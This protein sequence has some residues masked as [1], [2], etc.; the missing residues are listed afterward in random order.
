M[1]LARNLFL[2]NH[3]GTGFLSGSQFKSFL[4]NV[5][6]TEHASCGATSVPGLELGITHPYPNLPVRGRLGPP[7]IPPVPQFRVVFRLRIGVVP[8]GRGWSCQSAASGATGAR[9]WPTA[10]NLGPLGRSSCRADFRL[11]RCTW[12][13]RGIRWPALAQKAVLPCWAARHSPCTPVQ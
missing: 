4:F 2:Q 9:V 13:P 12:H 8:E 1:V 10:A 7:R 5:S 6:P 3:Y 11:G